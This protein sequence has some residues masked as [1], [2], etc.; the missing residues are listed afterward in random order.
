MSPEIQEVTSRFIEFIRERGIIGLA[1]GFMLGGA[2]SKVV[3]AFVNDVVN[4]L[5]GIFIGQ[6]ERLKELK[7]TVNSVDILWGDFLANFID[8]LIIAAVVYFVL[9]KGLGLHKLEKS[10]EL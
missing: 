3:S 9:F 6:T 2:V 10:K 5:I 8:F 4:P 7:T 1:I